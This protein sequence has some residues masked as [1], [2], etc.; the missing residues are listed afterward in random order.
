MMLS[1]HIKAT[2]LAKALL[3]FKDLF[4][5]GFFLSIGFTK[6]PDLT[7]FSAG[8]LLCLLL[9]VKML[10]YF[11]V[12]TRLKLRVRTAFLSG[13]VLNNY[14]EFG[15]IV[16]AVCV[17]AGWLTDE[18]LVIVAIAA[19][20]S[21]IFTSVYYKHAHSQYANNAGLLRQKLD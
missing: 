5:I 21:F 11:A 10:L 20:L 6:L 3:S 8:L 17:N 18:W 1:S 2:E 14:S 7:M 12:F 15:L 9:L 16:V 13:M 19:S 4:L